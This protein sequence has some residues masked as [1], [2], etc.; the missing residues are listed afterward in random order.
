MFMKYK[1][2]SS[3]QK[4][5]SPRAWADDLEKGDPKIILIPSKNYY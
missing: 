1:D 3:W 2:V 5:F 4:Q